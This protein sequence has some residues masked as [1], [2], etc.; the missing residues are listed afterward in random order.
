MG[1]HIYQSHGEGNIYPCFFVFRGQQELRTSI[2]A[3]PSLV[4]RFWSLVGLNVLEAFVYEGSLDAP[5]S[6][7]VVLRSLTCSN[8]C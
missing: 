5:I 3:P 8:Y 7:N 4:G 1:R 6:V 2:E